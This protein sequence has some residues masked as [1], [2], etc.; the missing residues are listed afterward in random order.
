MMQQ[1]VQQHLQKTAETGA[2]GYATIAV[3]GGSLSVDDQIYL[4][5]LA[6]G[7]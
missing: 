4:A 1:K 6:D 7:L 5:M 2:E 3:G